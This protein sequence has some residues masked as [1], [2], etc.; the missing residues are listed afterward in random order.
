MRD[1]VAFMRA[2]PVVRQGGPAGRPL[3]DGM[4]VGRAELCTAD[5]Q[6]QL[7]VLSGFYDFASESGTDPLISPVRTPMREGGWTIANRR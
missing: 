6:H 5:D 2:A 1:L 7:T 4:K 3:G